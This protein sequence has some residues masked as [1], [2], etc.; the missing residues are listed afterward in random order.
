MVRPAA[1]ALVA[2]TLVVAQP[3]RA[4]PRPTNGRP[5]ERPGVLMYH[6]IK[7]DAAG[8][9]VPWNADAP[10]HAFGPLLQSLWRFW[11][12]L[13]LD[14][15]GIPYQ[16]N[17]QVW[18]ERLDDVRGIGGDQVAQQMDSWRLLYA[19]LGEP[20][21]PRSSRDHGRVLHD[22]LASVDHYLAHSLSGPTDAWPN[23]PYPYNTL[24]HSGVYDGDMVIGKDYTQPDK[25]GSFGREL[26]RVWKLVDNPRYLQ[27]AIAIAD[28]LA[29]KIRAGDGD[30]SPWPFKVNARTGEVGLLRHGSDPA[31]KA[32]YTSAWTGT[33]ELFLELAALEGQHVSREQAKAYRAAFDAALKWMLAVPLATNKWGPFFEDVWGW[34]RRSTPS[35]SRRS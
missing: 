16:L 25:A 23:L 31:R 19:Y 7:T 3:T 22:L 13:P 32:D 21:D 8:H 5:P 12:A 18:N 14:R 20:T 10:G 24:V 4:D 34:S 35:R 33:L 11:D 28:T 9:I 27:V 6:A 2:A 15:N 1:F 30:R 17:H 29:K 26:V